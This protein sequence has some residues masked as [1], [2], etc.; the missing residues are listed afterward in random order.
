L[1]V[2]WQLLGLVAAVTAARVALASQLPVPWLVPDDLIY[3]GLARSFA[4]T[5]HFAFRDEPFTAWGFGPLYLVMIAP[6]FR[7]AASVP[8]AYFVIKVI[9]SVV[10][11]SAAVPAYV[12]AR[13][14]L[15]RR[16][17]VIAA[18]LAIL[19]PSGVYTGRLSPESL[20]YPA[21]LWAA[22]TILRVL[23]SPTRRREVLALLAIAVAMLSRAQLAVLFPAFLV[24]ALVMSVLDEQ[25]R[26]RRLL[27]TVVAG[28]RTFPVTSLVTAI[29]G[30][31]I[32]TLA[33]SGWSSADLLGGR[34]EVAGAADV[35]T[36]AKS[37]L[38]HLAVVD[39]YVGVLPFAA[40]LALCLRALTPKSS[41]ELRVFCVFTGAI[42][43]LTAALSARY[44]VAVFEGPYAHHQQYIRIYD[45]YVFYV[46]PLFLVAFLYWVGSDALR[47]SRSR[48]AIAVC[49]AAAVPLS[50]L[51]G[52]GAWKMPNSVAFLPWDVL[53]DATHNSAVVYAGLLAASAS[54][55]Y[56]FARSANVDW[57]VFLVA[58]NLLFTGLFAQSIAYGDSRRALQN[59]IGAGVDKAWI[60]EAVGRDGAAVALWSGVAERGERGRRAIWE[61]E[62]MNESVRRVYYL[63][64]GLPYGLPGKPLRRNVR[65]DYVLTDVE[66][67]VR[68][69]VV[70]RNPAV[71][72]VLYRVDGP[73]RLR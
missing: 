51:W 30:G 31:A 23:E 56:L 68:G 10:M 32:A 55:A 12:L 28:V 11:A 63:R 49:A 16:A 1:R 18:T 19:V 20:A 33:V 17:A 21:F 3:S 46:V 58:A 5:G 7:L 65:A 13:R 40:F 27:R 35:L 60:D 6:A 25:P 48:T 45:R 47:R 8:D 44:L 22:L 29:G 2:G 62:L 73:V 53:D 72:L 15:D 64:D 24:A 71:G 26:K 54:A 59:G 34:S 69:E 52:G 43:L 14:L 4:S 39:L 36:V 37:F 57:L 42:T 70:M 41:R 67:P 9:N 50:F 38:L 61:S 66:T